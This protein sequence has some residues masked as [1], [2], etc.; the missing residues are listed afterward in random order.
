VEN[1]ADTA[2]PRSM[3]TTLQSPGPQI[4][5]GMR[6][7]AMCQRR[8]LLDRMTPGAKPPVLGAGLR[9]LR[10]LLQ[11]AGSLTARLPVLLLLHRQIPHIPRVPAVRQRCLLLLRGRQ[12][13]KPR[14]IRTVTTD[15]DKPGAS[16]PAPL[17][18]DFLPGLESRSSNR[19]RLR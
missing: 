17:E 9:Q 13:S 14:H 4:G 2:T 7:N 8:V 12:Q 19:T 18:I 1:A 10:G 5:S 11:I 6:A 16:T 15:T 3:P